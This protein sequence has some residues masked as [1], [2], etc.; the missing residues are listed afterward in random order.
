MVVSAPWGTGPVVI[1]QGDGSVTRQAGFFPISTV[2]HP[3][4]VSGVP[5]AVDDVTVA[6]GCPIGGFSCTLFL[7]ALPLYSRGR[8]K[9]RRTP[10]N[11]QFSMII[12]PFILSMAL[13]L[14]LTIAF[15]WS[16]I[17]PFDLT[18]NP[19]LAFIFILDFAL[20]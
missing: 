8:N 7:L 12:E 1:E 5:C 13:D 19:P 11:S 15:D 3:G 17:I 9:N 6:A 16:F 14:I 4:P 20:A 2:G 10:A 18:W